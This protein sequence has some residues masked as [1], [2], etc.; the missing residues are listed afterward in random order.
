MTDEA[1]FYIKRQQHGR[2]TMFIPCVNGVK[3]G[4]TL[5]A[6]RYDAQ[7]ALNKWIAYYG[8]EELIARAEQHFVAV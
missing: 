6:R 7:A 8:R 5:Y 3:M 2:R 1:T 4:Q